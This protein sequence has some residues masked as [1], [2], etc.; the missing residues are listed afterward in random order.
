[1]R[2]TV[3]SRISLSLFLVVVMTSFLLCCHESGTWR[4]DSKNWERVFKTDKPDHITVVH[5][6][7]WRSPHF[8]LE[9]RYFIQVQKN[10]EFQERLLTMNPM[11]ELTDSKEIE[12][13]T[14]WLQ[15]KPPWFAQKPWNR[16]KIFVYSDKPLD[17]FRLLIDKESGDLFLADESL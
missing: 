5:S 1:M 16:Y 15:E 10:S 4:D 3:F 9:Y 13:A 12:M 7:Y 17:N 11:K 8:T 14:L 2:K 6:L